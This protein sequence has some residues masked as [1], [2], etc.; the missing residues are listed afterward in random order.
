MSETKNEMTTQELLSAVEENPPM[1]RPQ[2]L[3]AIEALRWA[4]NNAQSV[5]NFA[6]RLL[7][8]VL[9][10]VF[11]FLA[12]ATESSEIL[13]QPSDVEGLTWEQVVERISNA[14]AKISANNTPAIKRAYNLASARSWL[15]PEPEDEAQAHKAW[16]NLC[17]SGYLSQIDNGP[18]IFG[19]HSYGVDCQK[20]C[21]EPQDVR[22]ITR[23]AQ[24]IC[25][26]M[27]S[28][29]AV[30]NEPKPKPA[31]APMVLEE[32][33]A[34]DV[35]RNHAFGKF[36]LV[37][38]NSLG[39]ARKLSMESQPTANNGPVLIIIHSEGLPEFNSGESLSLSAIQDADGKIRTG[40]KL[41]LISASATDTT[42]K[43]DQIAHLGETLKAGFQM[44]LEAAKK[45]EQEIN[46]VDFLRGNIGVSNVEYPG[47]FRWEPRDPSEK[48]EFASHLALRCARNEKGQ[49]A[50]VKIISGGKKAEKLFGAKLGQFQD[51]GHA[52]EDIEPR[53]FSVFLRACYGSWFSK[54]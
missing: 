48:V 37:F 21:F 53:A 32:V 27:A 43:R 49:I 54:K 28:A 42:G 16:E 36:V 34:L 45:A 1:E 30:R 29:M 40:L 51:P 20:F 26:K 14:L 25:D 13:K 47:A 38:P 2:R 31:L 44:A 5:A 9:P 7:T 19:L 3:S 15:Y 52:F 39:H 18:V 46:P 50:L 4:Q 24:K 33:S 6:E 23:L 8:C 35:W 22:E 10:Q 17:A 12:V 41:N 11:Q